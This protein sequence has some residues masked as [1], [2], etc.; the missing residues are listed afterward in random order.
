[1]KYM[2]AM[3]Y[4][5][6]SKHSLY[7]D[8]YTILH[9]IQTCFNKKKSEIPIYVLSPYIHTFSTR[10][11][12]TCLFLLTFVD[13]QS[14]YKFSN[15]ITLP[16]ILVTLKFSP[17][18]EFHLSVPQVHYLNTLQIFMSYQLTGYSSPLICATNVV[19]EFF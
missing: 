6:T 2:L 7:L 4:V 11:L 13:F 15:H 3:L 1:M 5:S 12:Y 19:L 8:L 17:N 9:T 14:F 10:A 16:L 18:N